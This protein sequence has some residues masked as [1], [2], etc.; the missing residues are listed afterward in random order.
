MRKPMQSKISLKKEIILAALGIIAMLAIVWVINGP[1]T[2]ARL[3]VIVK[4]ETRSL[5][6]LPAASEAVIAFADASGNMLTLKDFHG[7]PLV[8]NLWATWCPPCISELPVLAGLEE[9]YGGKLQVIAISVD[10]EGVGAVD[11][12][13][14]KNDIRHPPF[15]YDKNG[16]LFRYLKLRGLPTTYILNADGQAVAKLERIVKENDKELL[17]LLDR[18]VAP[19]DQPTPKPDSK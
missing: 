5:T 8:M 3:R 12:F 16:A 4:E 7:K 14:A 1:L 18:L 2:E 11:A 17:S 10:A 13:L 9:R 15:Y 6:R 19:E